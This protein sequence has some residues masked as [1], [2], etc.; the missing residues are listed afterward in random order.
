[1]IKG[2]V[3][4][5][6]YKNCV[7]EILNEGFLTDEGKIVVKNK[8][9]ICKYNV[10]IF[11]KDSDSTGSKKKG[12]TT[13]LNKDSIRIQDNCPCTDVHCFYSHINKIKPDLTQFKQ[14]NIQECKVNLTQSN[15]FDFSN[16]IDRLLYKYYSDDK[17]KKVVE[18]LF[19]LNNI[20]RKG[21][22][23]VSID[24]FVSTFI[25]MAC[26]SIRVLIENYCRQKTSCSDIRVPAR[27]L[28]YLAYI[29][30]DFFLIEMKMKHTIFCNLQ[31]KLFIL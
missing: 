8:N 9:L 23:D 6:S 31:I 16:K 18:S 3:T 26:L 14:E 5:G 2:F 25:R 7:V 30:K 4:N 10:S 24:S 13:Y 15:L 20:S 21:Q 11:Y 12:Q 22:L 17:G 19:I 27:E 28:L 29:Q 1:M